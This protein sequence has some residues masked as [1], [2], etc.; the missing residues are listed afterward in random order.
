MVRVGFKYFGFGGL[1]SDTKGVKAF[2]GTKTGDGTSLVLNLTPD[3]KKAFRV[4]VM[5]DGPYANN[6]WNG[7]E[8]GVVEVRYRQMRPLSTRCPW[9]KG[10]RQ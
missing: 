10:H 5:L 3:C 4:R 6:V 8:I 1:D 2:R 7:R 9:S